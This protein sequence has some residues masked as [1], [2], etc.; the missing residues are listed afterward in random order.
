M[1][2]GVKCCVNSLPLFCCRPG[3]PVAAGCRCCTRRCRCCPASRISNDRKLVFD[4]LFTGTM[5]GNFCCQNKKIVTCQKGTSWDSFKRYEKTLFQGCFDFFFYIFRPY[6]Q[7][8]SPKNDLMTQKFPVF[9]KK[10]TV[11]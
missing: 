1:K 2:N 5:L 6:C 10:K 11:K 9:K 7:N 8:G 3:C 4:H